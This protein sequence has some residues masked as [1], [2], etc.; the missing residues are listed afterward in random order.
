MFVKRESRRSV[1]QV[2]VY[3]PSTAFNQFLTEEMLNFNTHDSRAAFEKMV[4]GLVAGARAENFQWP[5][6]P[7]AL[8]WD[9]VSYTNHDSFMGFY[10]TDILSGQKFL[11]FLVRNWIARS[12]FITP[13]PQV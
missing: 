3:L 9:G 4:G 7:V 2:P 13:I 11:S 12:R 6:R 5:V 1:E 10:V 8:Y